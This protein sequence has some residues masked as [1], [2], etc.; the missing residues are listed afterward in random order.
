MIF[1]TL[2][3]FNTFIPVIIIDLAALILVVII[4][5]SVSFKLRAWLRVVPSQLKSDAKK[6]IGT[7]GLL[8]IF[9]SELINRVIAQRNVITDSKT[10]LVTHLVVFWGFICLIIAT[11]WDDIF[12]RSGALPPPLAT[13][14][15]GNFIGNLGGGLVLVGVTA[16]VIRYVVIGRFRDHP[17]GDLTFLVTL[18]VAIISGFLTEVTRIFSGPLALYSYTFHLA[19][20]AALFVTAPFTH[21]FH[22]LLTPI[23]RYFGRIQSELKSR[24]ISDYPYYKKLEM[25]GLAE[26]VRAEKTKGTYPDWLDGSNKVKDKPESEG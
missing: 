26:K 14:N 3:Q 1:P 10:R 4:V 8:Q 24:G 20:V 19:V 11:I 13:E 12:F 9:F 15:P 17:K 23:M 5:A 6:H 18:Y 25:A 21:F 7:A 16:I 2:I 22:A